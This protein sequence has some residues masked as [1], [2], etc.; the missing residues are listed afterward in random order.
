MN[1]WLRLFW[2]LITAGLRGAIAIP[3]GISRLN[4][5]VWPH[6]LDTS[7]HMNNGRYLTIMDLGRLDMMVRSG[8]LRAAL[9]HKWTPI[10][11]T[12]KIRFRRELRPFTPFRLETRLVA[13]DA[14]YVV[15]EQTFLFAGG[16][17]DGQ[18]AAHALF[19]GGLYDRAERKFVPIARLMSEVGVAAESP[20]LSPEVEAFL[21]ADDELKRA[22][23]ERM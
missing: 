8:L 4:F 17:R 1:L 22:V 11:S 19:K 2:L 21:K 10:A 5:R 13:W 16:E 18:V 23:A 7:L 6:D 15:M 3:H 12:I 20:P 9:R 14:L